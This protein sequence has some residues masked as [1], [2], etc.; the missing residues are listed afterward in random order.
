MKERKAPDHTPNVKPVEKIELSER[1]I[2]LRIVLVVLFIAVALVAFGFAIV[3]VLS[4][5]A[6][7]R[8]VQTQTAEENCGGEFVFYYE[9][10]EGGLKGSEELQ[11]LTNAY[12]EVTVN[13]Y[14]IFRATEQFEGVYNLAYVNANPNRVV[15]VDDALYRAFETL[16]G[17][18]SRL[19]YYGP[20]Y[21]LYDRLFYALDDESAALYDPA[22]SEETAAL[23]A[24]LA[25]FAADEEC[26]GLE[27]LGEGR[28]RLNVSGEYMQFVRD[29]GFTAEDGTAVYLDF[30]VLRNAFIV[31]YMAENLIA[32]G[33]TH[34]ML[35]SYDG[36]SRVLEGEGSFQ[37]DIYDR[38]EEGVYLAGKASG[39][40]AVRSVQLRSYMISASERGYKYTY[41]DGTA[42]HAYLDEEGRC[43]SCMDELFAYSVRMSCAELMLAVLPVY[44]ADAFEESCLTALLSEG[45]FSVYCLGD[46]IVYFDEGL[47]VE[48]FSYADGRSYSARLKA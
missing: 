42:V 35:T 21:Q 7:W 29:N 24:Q 41:A 12:N 9:I 14:R 3:S 34:G 26:I 43:A 20:V 39:T 8:Q 15:T 4:T 33:Y 22:R 18:A 38:T 2:K 47:A 6:G 30:F 28:V 16:A 36:Y 10:Q 32:A 31:D 1:H 37:T 11:A 48:V 25:A 5:D 27:L 45:I 23:V 13:A 44:T 46:E 40:G 17:S 19:A